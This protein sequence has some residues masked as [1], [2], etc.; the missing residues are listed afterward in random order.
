MSDL[1]RSVDTHKA[2]A[3]P[4]R[5]RLVAML[6]EGELCVCQ[7]TAVLEL[8][9][10]TV[11]AHLADLKRAGLFAESKKGRFVSYGRTYQT[12]RQTRI[13]VLPVGY[14]HGLP[15]LLSNRGEVLVRGR[16]VPIV[17]RVTMDLTMVDV[18]EVPDIALGDEVVLFG[19]QSGMSVSLEEVAERANTIPYDILCSMG[20]RVVRVFLRAGRPSKVL[21]LVGERHETETVEAA[22]ARKARKVQYRSTRIPSSG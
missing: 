19:E 4:V 7:M 15:W 21:T 8:A 17:G 10:S 5:Q 12:K 22:G 1:A 6:R 16:R 11:S 14:G 2:L 13:G 18:T 3:H 20:K 9:A